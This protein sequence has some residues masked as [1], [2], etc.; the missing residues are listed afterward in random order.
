LPPRLLLTTAI[1]DRAGG[2]NPAG[3]GLFAS[4]GVNHVGLRP[5]SHQVAS[6]KCH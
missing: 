1:N 2:N 4:C 6:R 5:K 3:Q